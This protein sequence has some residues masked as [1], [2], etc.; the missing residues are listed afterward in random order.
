MAS[1]IFIAYNL[2]LNLRDNNCLSS[3]RNVSDAR[4]PSPTNSIPILGLE[5]VGI[6]WNWN[7][8]WSELVGIGWNWNRNWS[9][10]GIGLELVGIS[11]NWNYSGIG[12]ELV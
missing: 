12:L 5:L 6:D 3:N 7:W 9:G 2:I 10:I 1:A 8:N 4:I 11:W